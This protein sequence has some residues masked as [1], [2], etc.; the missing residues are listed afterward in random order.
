MRSPAAR[1]LLGAGGATKAIGA[2]EWFGAA[3]LAA[4]LLLPVGD[5]PWYS[6]WR[7]WTAFIAVTLVLLGALSRLRDASQPIRV[8]TL[9]LPGL[10]LGLAAVCWLQFAAGL[11]PYHSDALL[12]SIYLAAFA[13]LALAASSLPD[14][15]KER[16]AD[17]LAVAMV[18]AAAISVPLAVGQWLGWLRLDMGMRVA[19]GRPVAHMEQAN[20]LCTLLIQGALGL[21]RL[22]ERGRIGRSATAL[23][24]GPILFAMILTQSRVAWLVGLGLVAFAWW[25][26]D[27]VPASRWRL[28]CGAAITVV[29]GAFILP[30][31]DQVAGLPGAALSERFSEGRR[32]AAWLLF[33]EAGLAR[34]WAGWGVMQNGTAQYALADAHPSLGYVFSSAHNVVLDLVIWFGIPVGLLAGLSLI[35]VVSSR[36]RQ[37]SS[38]YGLVTAVSAAAL[39]LHALVELPLHYAYFLLPLGLYLGL[40]APRGRP[41]ARGALLVST[42]QKALIS[43]CALLAALMLSLLGSEYIR[44][45]EFRPVFAMDKETRH[46]KLVANLPLPDVVLLDQLRAFHAFAALPLERG[47]SAIDLGKAQVAMRRAPYSASIEHY[48]L[49]AGIDGRRTETIDALRR[50]CKFATAKQCERI[51]IAW[52]IWRERWP[53]LPEADFGTAQ[54]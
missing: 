50:V 40:T 8:P 19:G 47:T 7:E 12:G 39:V 27:L 14:E 49:L 13:V 29:A 5:A 9:S 52:E 24:I 33:V 20:L 16:M 37:A 41:A 44:I 48:A 36:I 15:E 43:G 30:W 46:P 32:P 38:A 3:A 54:P 23:L 6:F 11:L 22:A 2:V 28:L 17:R 34:P 10:A 4:A 35:W 51:G 53:Q 21:W 42:E 25:R 26:R 45:T 31:L 1:S 18:A